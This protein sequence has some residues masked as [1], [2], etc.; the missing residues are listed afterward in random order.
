M[1]CPEVNLAS[2]DFHWRI[3]SKGSRLNMST[4]HFH[5]WWMRWPEFR[6]VTYVG[7]INHLSNLLYFSIWCNTGHPCHNVMINENG[8][9]KMT[10]IRTMECVLSS[11]SMDLPI[12]RRIVWTETET[13]F[14]HAFDH[15]YSLKLNWSDFHLGYFMFVNGLLYYTWCWN[16]E[17]II[18]NLLF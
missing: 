7:H 12:N 14:G 16:Y 1:Q 18:G 6:N 10:K 3:R 8:L 2:C 4:C 13:T 17:I 11:T 15:F 9:S 5:I